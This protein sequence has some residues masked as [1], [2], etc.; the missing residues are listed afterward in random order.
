MPPP[1]K[2]KNICHPF[3]HG[4]LSPVPSHSP[5]P[6]LAAPLPQFPHLAAPQRLSPLLPPQMY[7]RYTQDLGTFA[8]DEAARL[9]LQQEQGDDGTPQPRR[10]S[11]LLEYSQG[12]C[13]P[14]CSEGTRRGG[15]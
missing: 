11:E 14:R 4:V 2:K 12:R 8:K 13:A 5:P 7:G 9:R 6:V 1:P 15:Q 10:P 3:P